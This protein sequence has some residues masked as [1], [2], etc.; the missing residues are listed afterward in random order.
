MRKKKSI[1]YK[2]IF[3]RFTINSTDKKLIETE[4]YCLLFYYLP[5]KFKKTMPKY[6]N[7]NKKWQIHWQDFTFLSTPSRP[8]LVV[9][10]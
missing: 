3:V 1:A 6:Y 2:K 5:K 10:W 9:Q 8:Y 7:R 4:N